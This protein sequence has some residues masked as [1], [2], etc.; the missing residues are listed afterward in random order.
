MIEWLKIIEGD[1]PLIISIP[2]AGIIIPDDVKGLVSKEKA[3]I[4]ADF[5]IDKLYE[6]AKDFGA[7]IIKTEISRAVIDVNRNPD[8]QSLYPGQSVTELCPTTSF[9][10]SKLYAENH[11]PDLAEIERRRAKYYTPYHSQ[12][13]HQIQ[14]LRAKNNKIILYDAHS[15]K[16]H[17]PRFFEGELPQY[18]IGTNDGESCDFNLSNGIIRQCPNGEYVLNGRFKGGFITRN[19]GSPEN[20]IHAVQMELAMR[21]YINESAPFPPLWQPDLAKPCQKILQSILETCILFAKS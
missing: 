10:N 4:D 18:N 9:D 16:S 12:I 2:H 15:I 5:Y 14:R 6:F 21:G 8:G 3:I 17:V 7:T 11:E 19:Y 1:A 13:K 20:G